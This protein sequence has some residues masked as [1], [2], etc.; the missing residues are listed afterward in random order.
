ML[1]D[2]SQTL[3]YNYRMFANETKCS[4]SGL[5]WLA[6]PKPWLEHE[7]SYLI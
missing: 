7:N 3:D 2:F 4:K 5:G 1:S 6:S